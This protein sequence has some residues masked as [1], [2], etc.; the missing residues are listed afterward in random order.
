[1]NIKFDIEL[2]K[3]INEAIRLSRE[4]SKTAYIFKDGSK[5]AVTTCTWVVRER[6]LDKQTMIATAYRGYI[7]LV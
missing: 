1:M 6:T 7:Q 3:A 2:V 4:Y 5:Y